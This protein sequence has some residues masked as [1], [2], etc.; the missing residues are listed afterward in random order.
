MKTTVGLE[1]AVVDPTHWAAH[2]MII[3]E[4]EKLTLQKPIEF[5][6]S[7]HQKP[8]R[9]NKKSKKILVKI[10]FGL[11]SRW[12]GVEEKYIFETNN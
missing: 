6:P 9:L 8:M 12:Q 7:F 1:S 2:I 11:S 4:K 10:L 5:M 3:K